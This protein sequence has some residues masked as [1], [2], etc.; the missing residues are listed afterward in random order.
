M[1][2]EERL[3]RSNIAV[4]CGYSFDIILNGMSEH[5]IQSIQIPLSRP[6]IH[7]GIDK[8]CSIEGWGE[9]YAFPEL[10]SG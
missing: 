5:R 1:P 9:D 7:E 4:R 2:A 3:P 6:F 8:I 10:D